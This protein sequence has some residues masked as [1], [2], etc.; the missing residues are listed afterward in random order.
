VRIKER[1][2]P[3]QEIRR[4]PNVVRLTGFPLAQPLRFQ[5]RRDCDGAHRAISALATL[6]RACILTPIRR[7]NF[8][9]AAFGVP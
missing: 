8:C 1:K 2:E 5:N 9:P 3:N 7:S 4:L 6:A